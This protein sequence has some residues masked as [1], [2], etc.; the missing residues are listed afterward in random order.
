M[1]KIDI[2]G[3]LN[4]LG[5]KVG[6]YMLM[7]AIVPLITY[8]ILNNIVVSKY[9]SRIE[10]TSVIA[11]AEIANKIFQSKALDLEE[12]AKDNGIWDNFYQKIEEKDIKWFKKNYS[13]WIPDNFSIDLIVIANKNGEIIDQYGLKYM[14]DTQLFDD[15]TISDILNGQYDKKKNYPSGMKVY[16]GNLYIIG[17]SPILLSNYEGPSRGMVIFGKKVTPELL[18]NIKDKFGYDIFF[19]YGNE[20]VPNI[21]ISKESED[22]FDIIHE[23]KNQKT[24]ELG[25]SKIVGSVLIKDICNKKLGKL[26]IVESRDIFLS[27][28][29]LIHRNA[30]LIFALACILSLILGIKL[31]NIIVN[32]MKGLENEI[33]KMREK[34][35]PIQVKT[36]GSNEFI[37]FSNSLVK[38]LNQMNHSIYRYKKENKNLR[39]ISNTDGLTSLYNH[40]YFYECFNEKIGSERRPITV[41]FCDIDKF[42]LIN[43]IHGHITG[44]M[45]LKEIGNIIK[46]SVGENGLIFRYGGEEFA[47][48][49]DNY[50]VEKS[51]E[52]AEN[53]RINIIRSKKIQKYSGDVPVTISIGLSSYPDDSVDAKDLIEKADKAMYFAK[54]NGRNQCC[55]YKEEVDKI[56][57]QDSME[58]AKQ[59]ILIDSAFAISAAIDAKDVYTGKH[60]ELVTRYSLL[61]AEKLRLSV[62]DKYVLRIGALLHDCGKIGIPDDI[63]HKPTRLTDEEFNT[64]KNH[65]ILGNNIAKHIVKNPVIISCVRNHHE[66]WDGNGYPDGLSG[67]SIPMHARIVCVADAYHAMISDRPYRKSLSQDEAFEELRKNKGTQFDPDLV[68]VF[69]ETVQEDSAVEY[70]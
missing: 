52:I 25:E 27:T 9:F 41:L 70:A 17:M 40:R 6:A 38:S 61:L 69:I 49:M 12:L 46:Q 11:K 30:F 56:I 68:D 7:V 62:Q 29:S 64:I 60:S 50:T 32:P 63:I 28:L 34:N 45:V 4:N 2:K 55:I 66:R 19:S 10:Q 48:M 51:F 13:E 31:K 20:I 58:F 1:F 5:F 36:N 14:N 22:F 39:L 8:V 15:D 26:Y 3:L 35:V 65:T 23:S 33:S 67:K 59:E 43:D 57:I 54:Q 42:K 53:I 47:V 21:E 37:E 16:N 18:Q 44:D 24:F